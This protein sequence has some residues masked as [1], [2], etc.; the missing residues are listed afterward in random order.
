VGDITPNNWRVGASLRF[1]PEKLWGWSILPV[2][3]GKQR[4]LVLPMNVILKDI[5][6]SILWFSPSLGF[7]IKNW[8]TVYV[9]DFSFVHC[10]F[11][12]QLL[13][14]NVTLI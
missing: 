8:F 14:D 1:Y 5:R 11:T 6:K 10:L 13:D 3:A 9:Y 7:H 4:K 2:A 12:L